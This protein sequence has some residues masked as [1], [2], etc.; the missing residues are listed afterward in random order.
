M[1]GPGHL[2]IFSV[3]FT[4]FDPLTRCRG[5]V[6]SGKNSSRSEHH[7]SISCALITCPSGK[8]CDRGRSSLNILG[9][10]VPIPFGEGAKTPKATPY[11]I[12]FSC[13]EKSLEGCVEPLCRYVVW[14]WE[15]RHNSRSSSIIWASNC[16]RATSQKNAVHSSM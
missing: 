4:A 16:S 12:I 10:I 1:R 7:L 15:N 14:P 3:H 8:S 6:Q 2:V 5:G 11:N 9:S 13:G